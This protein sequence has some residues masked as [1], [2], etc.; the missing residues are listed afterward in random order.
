MD[1]Y[2]TPSIECGPLC[3]QSVL[4]IPHPTKFPPPSTDRPCESTGDR[5][6]PIPTVPEHRLFWQSTST[7]GFWRPI[8]AL[9]QTV[10]RHPERWLVVE[11][12]LRCDAKTVSHESVR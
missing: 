7:L 10:P 1:R 9:A 12:S 11:Q 3:P 6:S 8:G 4:W 5:Q 2:P